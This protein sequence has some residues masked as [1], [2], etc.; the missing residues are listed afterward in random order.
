MTRLKAIMVFSLLVGLTVLT[1]AVRMPA[2]EGHPLTGTWS[3]DFG[4]N[5]KDRIQV[6]LILTLEG[7][8]ITG[9]ANPGPNKIPIKTITV[10]SAKQWSVHF[11]TDAKDAACNMAHFTADGK[12]DLAKLGSYHR[13]IAG[14]YQFG[15]TKGDF[16][17]QRD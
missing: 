14:T 13:T 11:E 3:G 6:T 7:K 1:A 15:S 4:P 12:F 5:A 10:D 16:K 8:N 9:Y 2:Q 17:L